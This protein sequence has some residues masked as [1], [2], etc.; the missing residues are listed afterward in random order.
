MGP[1]LMM[2]TETAAIQE[3]ARMAEQASSL[4]Y[5]ADYRFRCDGDNDGA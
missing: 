1:M 2:K 4:Y 5:A 3:S